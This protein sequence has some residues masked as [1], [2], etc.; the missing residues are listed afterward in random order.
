MAKLTLNNVTSGYI[1]VAAL[2]ENFSTIESAF[3]NVVSRDGTSPNTMTANLDMNGYGLLNV[4]TLTVNGVDVADLV[5]AAI[6]AEA[7]AAAALVSETNAATSEA[8]AELSAAL[9][10]DWSF[11]GS[12]ITATPYVVNNIVTEGGETYICLVDHT[13][14]TF[15]TDYGVA[16]WAKL[17]AKGAAGA[18]TGDMLRAN[19]LS[20]VTSAA[21]SLANI[22]GQP[23][24]THLTELTT[25]SKTDGN[26]IVTNG[27]TYVAESGATARTSLGAAADASV[28]TVWIPAGAMT[29]RT[30]SGAA[31]GT[32]ET[33]TNKVMLKTLDFDASADEF[34]QFTIRMPKGWNEGTI[35]AAFRWSH[36][37]TT[38]NFG[39]IWGIQAVAVSDDDALDVAFGTAQVVT[40]T[41]GTTNDIYETGMTA[42]ITVGGTPAEGDMVIFQ[43][44]RDVAAYSGGDTMAIDA[45]LH[46]IVLTYTTTSLNDA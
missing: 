32:V 26:F 15:S 45:R 6:A 23:I 43:V 8:E 2:N 12:W 3:E 5:D 1:S 25:L 33:T 46:G 14:G 11:E 13:A 41:G 19:N 21:T 22:G 27:S 24:N 36:A 17:A 31:S 9:V 35:T 34:V 28:Q 10:A 20:D 7:S 29:T 37:A 18:G 30:T 39:V 42:A 44:Y 4:S 38:T 40:D 16:K